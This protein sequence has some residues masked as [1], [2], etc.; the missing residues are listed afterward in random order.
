VL[1][2][3]VWRYY[4]V[5][6]AVVDVPPIFHAMAL[7]TTVLESKVLPAWWLHALDFMP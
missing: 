7:V 3:S 5:F 2:L 6:I 4:K 1:P